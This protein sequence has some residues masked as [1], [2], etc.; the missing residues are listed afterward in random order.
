MI[1]EAIV[2]GALRGSA[3][4]V[5]LLQDLVWEGVQVLEHASLVRFAAYSSEGGKF[6]KLTRLGQAALEKDAVDRILGGGSL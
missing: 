1:A 2:P 3:D 5:A 6:F 4:Q